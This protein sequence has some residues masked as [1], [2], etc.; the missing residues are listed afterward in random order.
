MYAMYVC[1]YTYICMAMCVH[2]CTYMY[3]TTYM[4][5]IV[6]GSLPRSNDKR[7]RHVINKIGHDRSIENGGR[8]REAFYLFLPH[9]MW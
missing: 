7:S 4:Y 5:C 1:T 2:M 8:A 9:I 6:G 3:S